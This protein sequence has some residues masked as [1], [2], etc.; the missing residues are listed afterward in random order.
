MCELAYGPPPDKYVA[1]HS[2]NNGHLGCVNPNH[3][4]WKTKSEDMKDRLKTGQIFNKLSIYDVEKIRAST[5]KVPEIANQFNVSQ[6][7]VYRILKK[8]IWR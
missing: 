4:S 8:R 5:N 7:T 2:C 6:S 3:L 1:A